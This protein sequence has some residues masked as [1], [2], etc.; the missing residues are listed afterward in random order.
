MIAE[1]AMPDPDTHMPTS[2]LQTGETHDFNDCWPAATPEL[3]VLVPTYKDSADRLLQALGN[4]TD[5]S[6]VEVIIYDD[7]SA[8]PELT[9][10]IRKAV[11]AFTGAACLVTCAENKGRSAG[12][13]RLQDLSRSDWLL[14]LD[15]DMVPDDPK[16]L[17]NYLEVSATQTL[18]ALIVGGFSLNQAH[19]TPQNE[20]HWAQSIRSE[21]LSAA[22]RNENP[23]RFVFTSNVLAHRDIMTDVAFDPAFNGWGWEDVDWGIRVAQTYP[24]VHIDNT[25]THLGLDTP[26]TLMGKYAASG[27]NFW[28]VANRHPESM[29]ETP[30]VKLASLLSRIPGRSVIQSMSRTLAAGPSWLLPV[31][32]RLAAL[33]LYRA[34]VYGGTRHDHC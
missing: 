29:S 27:P 6:R 21:C 30:L 31:S 15:A 32:L 8:D 16:F 3:S 26:N 4:C 28:L 2:A 11:K 22:L 1:L 24:V 20:L 23:G 13:N 17:T 33:K 9:E 10:H 19:P 14:F 12:R 18:P 7:G 5:T 34:A 25:A